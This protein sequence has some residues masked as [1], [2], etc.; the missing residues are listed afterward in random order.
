MFDIAFEAH[1]ETSLPFGEQKTMNK[2]ISKA[3]EVIHSG[4]ANFGDEG[5]IC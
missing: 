1:P 5:S 3:G 2:K 4:L